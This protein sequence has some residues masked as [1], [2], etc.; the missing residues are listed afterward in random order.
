MQKKINDLSIVIATLGDKSLYRVI[1]SILNSTY[2][3]KEI[4]LVKPTKI[5]LDHKNFKTDN[6][7]VFSSYNYGQVLQR[8]I[9]F[10]NC[11]TEYVMQLDDDIV[12]NNNSIE[13]LY[14]SILNKKNACI[15]PIL[16]YHEDNESV[17]NIDSINYIE[18]IIRIVANFIR[19]NSLKLQGQIGRS[20]VAFG[21]N[22]IEKN[23]EVKVNW[24]PGGCIIHR[25]KNL[26]I[27]NFYP[28]K[29]K[30]YSEDLIHSYILTQ[31]KI[32][33]FITSKSIC[34]I[35]KQ[36]NTDIQKKINEFYQTMKS[37]LLIV[38]LYKKSMILFYIDITLTICYNFSK[39]IL[40]NF[41]NKFAKN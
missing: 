31:N 39:L 17:Y 8:S 28:Y 22:I 4:I 41:I 12:L 34:Y 35:Y 5:E 10:N 40:T 20:G 6:I 16:R 29:G 37:R 3:P 26:I 9:G 27:D 23:S 2:L 25:A 7:K 38:R 21:I 1:D 30:A 18:K 33:L 24:L 36:K 14:L 32:D 13:N 15:A 11:K 19:G